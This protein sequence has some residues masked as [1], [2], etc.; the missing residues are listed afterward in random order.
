MPS[1]T[2]SYRDLSPP[3]DSG[4][5]RH[6]R[7]DAAQKLG[8]FDSARQRGLSQRDAAKEVGA[9][10]T[11][12]LHWG[13]RRKELPLSKSVA[14][15]LETP[16]GQELARRIVLAATFVLTLR[17]PD[18]VRL[19]CEFL[20]LC[21]LAGVVGTSFGT[22]QKLTLQMQE[23]V[24]AFGDEQRALLGQ[25]MPKKAVTICA[26]ETF[27]PKPCLVAIE[28]T[29]NF[30][31]LERY[32]EHRDAETWNTTMKEALVDLPVKVVQSTSDQGKALLCHARD[33]EAHHSPDLFHP[34]HDLS[35]AT[36]LPLVRRVRQAAE[37]HEYAVRET[38][39]LTEEFERY[40]S[41]R[42][43]PGRPPA[44]A[45]RIEQ[46]Q[47]AA[48]A[49]HQ[50][51]KQA[52]ADQEACREAITGISKDYHCYRVTDGAVQSAERVSEL[53][54]ARFAVIDEIA[55]RA[56]LSMKCRDRIDK[57]R[58]VTVDMV[59]TIAFVHTETAVRLLGLELS[60]PVQT[61][62][63][64]KLV[65][66]LY[67]QRV[68]ARAQFADDRRALLA[69][70]KE[71]LAPLEEPDN[72]LKL[73]GVD[74]LEQVEAVAGTCAGLFQRSTSCVEGRNGQLSL[75]HHGLHRLTDSKLAALTVVHNFHIRRPDGTTPADRFFETQHADLFSHLLER[76]P[77]LARP[78]KPRS[79]RPYKA[80][81]EAAA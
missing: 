66:G 55:D 40:R 43:G 59:A 23:H 20:E 25:R 54:G 57:A 56:A 77:Q 42:H 63:T 30:I 69:T 79:A 1:P 16:A 18:G 27:H 51:L 62:V 17:G 47:E 46:A 72:P 29:S 71:L 49:A 7:A 33:L 6:D 11:T 52:I 70:A 35:K 2:T 81:L 75:F 48:A 14:A 67:L 4:L 26:D 21:G 68:A 15:F 37:R 45:S 73:L 64:A 36:A 65:P 5:P 41:K 28:P 74:R 76:M 13:N 32:V 44:F 78:A 8:D 34:Q 9:P 12:L 10:R 39:R 22:V 24:T 61:E 3:G 50:T 60:A 80:R 58:R 38:T 19:V 53:L 31:V